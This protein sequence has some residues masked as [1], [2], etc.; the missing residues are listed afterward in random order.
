MDSSE[1]LE[2]LSKIDESLDLAKKGLL[3]YTEL[4]E[5]QRNVEIALEKNIDH[6]T[7][8]WRDFDRHRTV[9]YWQKYPSSK[10]TSETGRL[11]LW[12]E[13][14]V[15]ALEAKGIN[16]NRKQQLV[17]KGQYFTARQIIREVLG[18]A[19]DRID[20]QDNYANIELLAILENYVNENPKLKIRIL[21][22]RPINTF[23]SDLN[24]F[25]KQYGSIIEVKTHLDCHDRFIFIDGNEVYHSGHSFK[26]LGSKASLISSVEN[27]EEKKKLIL[28]FENW[29][30]NGSPL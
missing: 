9:T 12:R 2:M 17:Q 16:E 14:I 3:L 18:K 25:I 28:E 15:K 7:E 6:S 21:T 20:I 29:W 13:F 27:E 22:Q 5:L 26:D 1:L 30:S 24:T 23:K 4:Q 8:L 11:P 19:K 10:Y